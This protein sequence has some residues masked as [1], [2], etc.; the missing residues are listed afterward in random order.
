MRKLLYTHS[1]DGELVNGRS[2][3]EI[4]LILTPEPMLTTL[5]LQW[6]CFF[7]LT[8]CYEKIQTLTEIEG[9]VESAPVYATSSFNDYQI[10]LVLFYLF[11]PQTI[12]F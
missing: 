7:K 4:A 3:M 5:M 12:L 11:F 8:F 2:G 1:I 6:Q 9:I 10:R